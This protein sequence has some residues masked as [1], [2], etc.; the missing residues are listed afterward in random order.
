MS[1]SLELKKMDGSLPSE[2]AVLA[3][4]DSSGTGF[5]CSFSPEV[6]MLSDPK[7]ARAEAIR[8]LRTHIM[9]QHVEDGRRG[10]AI[11]AA[12]ADVGA[13]FTAV[14]LAVSLAQIGVKVLLVDGDLRH[15]DLDRFIRPSSEVLG[16]R[17]CLDARDVDISENIQN[18][19]LENLSVMFAGGIAVNAQE[20][21]ASDR[22]GD[23]IERC[24]RD[25]DLTIIDTPPANSCADARRISTVA[26]YSLLV[27]RRH[28][29]FVN[30]I[31]ALAAQLREDRAQVVGTVLSEA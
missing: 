26:G 1:M 24:L 11:C 6:V 2:T 9:A 19:V 8:T 22:F 18:E 7:G 27:A 17:Q 12:S 29:T 20:L 21:L 16:L 23:V 13:T 3:G 4:S 14:N 31:K 25:Y 15:A 28:H 30:D 5:R 10:L